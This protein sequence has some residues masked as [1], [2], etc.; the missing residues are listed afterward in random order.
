MTPLL[1]LLAC[2]PEADRAPEP[3]PI[4]V[5]EEHPPPKAGPDGL[6]EAPGVE[7]VRAHCGGCH[8]T[9]LVQQN[10]MSRERWDH[11]LTWMQQTQGRWDLPPAQRSAI[12][13][14]LEQWQGAETRDSTSSPWASPLYEPN[15]IW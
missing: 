14:Y 15:P 9:A 2:T 12:L 7:L 13:D 4:E 5:V 10:H 11:T 6:M 1:W 8:S 3:E